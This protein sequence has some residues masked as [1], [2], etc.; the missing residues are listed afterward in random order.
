MNRRPLNVL[1]SG[2]LLILLFIHA[3]A[4]APPAKKEMT[5]EMAIREADSA[6]VRQMNE[7]L[8]LNATTSSEKVSRDYRIGAEDL[9]EITV[10]EEDKLNKVVR[11]SAQGNIS[12]PL[13][14]VLKVKGL[15]AGQLES[16]VRDLLGEK[17]LHH[18]QVGVF[19]KEYRNQ[20]ISVTGAVEKPGVYDVTGEKVML[21]L[22]SMAGG[23]KEDAGPM[24]FLIR[25]APSEETARNDT[26]R[27]DG[28]QARQGQ[29]TYV[30]SLEDLLVKGDSDLN[31][32][33][34]HGDLI[35]IP[36]SGKVFVAGE[37]NKPGGFPLKGKKMTVG[38]AIA[39]SEGLKEEAEG[40]EAKIFRY[41]DKG[42]KREIVAVNVTTVLKGESED[43]YLQE[44]D[45]LVI[46]RSGIKYFLINV[47]NT[48]KGLVGFGFTL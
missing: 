44:N 30:I 42:Q 14:G 33:L 27:S 10:F 36:V 5:P 32:P 45:I 21:D 16:E 17:Y 7:R 35:N 22:L 38:Q 31:L 29:K 24:L 8:L 2:C 23:L 37:V 46:P 28:T 40:S 41:T 39:M 25:R 47:R 4:S 48:L 26:T 9:L 43:F 11:V 13:I 19:I 3:C 18:P 6:H 34:M 15:T 20:R 12:L 1:Y